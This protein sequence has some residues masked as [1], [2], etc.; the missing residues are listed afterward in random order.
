MNISPSQTVLHSFSPFSVIRPKL[1]Q[2]AIGI[3]VPIAE[4]YAASQDSQYPDEP[5]SK[6]QKLSR[7]Q[8]KESR[9]FPNVESSISVYSMPKKEHIIENICFYIYI[10]L[11]ML[12]IKF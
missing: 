2:F 4:V 7:P 5:K 3:L 12:I 9:H 10:M 8:N 11:H 6:L 1:S